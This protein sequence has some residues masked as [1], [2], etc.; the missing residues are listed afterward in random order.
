MYHNYDRTKSQNISLSMAHY[1]NQRIDYE[2]N[3][4]Y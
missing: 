4:I 2:E 1:K 3:V